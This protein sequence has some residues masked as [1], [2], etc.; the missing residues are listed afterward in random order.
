MSLLL[1]QRFQI[2]FVDDE[3]AAGRSDCAYFSGAFDDDT[4]FVLRDPAPPFG[5]VLDRMESSHNHLRLTAPSNGKTTHK[6]KQAA[7][8]SAFTDL[9]NRRWPKFRRSRGGFARCG[10]TDEKVVQ[11]TPD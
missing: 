3:V 5:S 10:F 1:E 6:Q 8:S 2:G 11:K 9:G 7:T 4:D